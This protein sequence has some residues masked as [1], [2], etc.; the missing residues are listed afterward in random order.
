[1]LRTVVRSKIHRAT[2][3]RAD[4]DYEGSLSIDAELMRLADI[5]PGEQVHVV[6]VTNGSRA[7]TYA[8]EGGPGEMGLN[9]AI[10]HLG[11]PG[12]IVI[13]ITYAQCDEAEL[14]R[15]VPRM[16]RVDAGNRALT[17]ARTS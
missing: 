3:T 17:E 8:I 7:V 6:N 1:V 9:G 2:V 14:S 5:C 15:H 16:V 4:L 10:A 12:D 11:N 13:A